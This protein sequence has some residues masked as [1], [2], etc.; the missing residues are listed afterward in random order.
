[1]IGSTVF[2]AI[3]YAFIGIV[4]SG[5]LP[6]AEVE[7]QSL[8]LVAAEIFP[9]P[10][11]VF[12]IIGGGMFAVASTLNASFSWCTKGLLVAA[13]EGWL[14]KQAA[15]IGKR[16]T[17]VV[18]LTIFYI[19]G[20][21]P[22][23][24]GMSIDVI[25]RL[26]NGLSLIYVLFPIACGYLI[27]KKNPEAM[28]KTTFKMGKTPLYIFTTVGLLGYIMAA[29]LNFADIQSAWQMILVYF[30]VVITYAFIR[31]KHVIKV[32]AEK[33]KEKA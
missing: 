18:L 13:E 3:I 25:S 19:V 22:I 24:T 12:F 31:E 5:V 30:A 11:Y 4:A 33:E 26:G 23:L 2:V 17:P 9:K 7:G 32:A 28:A 15:Y 16:G 14:P 21:I 27:H 10:L 8:S 29:I 1:M 6:I 20:A